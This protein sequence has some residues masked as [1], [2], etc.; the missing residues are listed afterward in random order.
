MM[1]SRQLE[2]FFAVAKT[3]RLMQARSLGPGQSPSEGYRI[4]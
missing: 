2:T 4:R 3:T 1:T